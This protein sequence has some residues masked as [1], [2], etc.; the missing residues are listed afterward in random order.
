M[1][2]ITAWEALHD[3]AHITQNQT[4]LIHAGAGGVGH[5]TIQLAKLA[6]ARVITTVSTEEKVNFAKRLDADLTINY[7]TQDVV[8]EVLRWTNDNGMDIV[9]DTAGSKMLQSCFRCFKPYGDIV[10]ILQSAPDTDWREARVRNIRFSLEL[11]LTPA[12]FELEDAKR[13]Q[14]EILQQCAT[15]FNTHKYR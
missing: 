10:T 8:A 9:L 7:C 12:L 2:F 13:H 5:A 3:R 11:M 1:I 15:L 14:G 6:G 4:V